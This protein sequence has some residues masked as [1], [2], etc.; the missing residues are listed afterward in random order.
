MAYNYS[1]EIAA[2]LVMLVILLHFFIYRQF[3]MARTGIFGAYVGVSLAGC[4]CNIAS[5]LGCAYPYSLPLWAN[6]VLVVLVFLLE[7]SSCYLFFIY[8]LLICD[9]DDRWQKKL[10][11]IGAIPLFPTIFLILATPFT[12]W[13]YYFDADRQYTRSVLGNVGY[14]LILGYVLA[15]VLLLLSNRRKI[16]RNNR[17]IIMLYSLLMFV[18]FGI[19]LYSKELLLDGIT[20]AVVILLIYVSMQSP[21]SLVDSVSDRYNELAF[22]IVVE[23]K[24]RRRQ[25]FAVLCLHLNKFNNISAVIGYK[26]VDRIIEQ[27]GRFLAQTGG[28]E[29]TYRTESHVFSLILPPDQEKVTE[30]VHKIQERFLQKWKAGNLDL[31]LNANIVTACSPEHFESISEM[32]ALRDYMMEYAKTKG[33]NSLVVADGEVKK[34]YLRL[35]SVERAINKAIE[36]NSLEVFYQPIYSVRE[37]KMVAAEA[38][39]RLHDEVLGNISPGEFIPIAEKNG[40]IIELGKQIFEKCCRFI[41][42]ELVPHPE[43]EISSI[44]VNL[45]VVQCIQPDMSEQFIRIIE[46]YNIPP[47]ML[48]LELTERITLGATE[49]MQ[50]HMRKLDAYG[51]RFALDD[52]GTGSSN[53]AYLID[54]A[55]GMVKFDKQM[56]DSYFENETAHKIL[57]NEF[58]T[59]KELGIDIV[60]EGI[61]TEEQ[62]KRLKEAEMN[63]IQGFYFAKPAPMEQ[64]LELIRTRKQ[65]EKA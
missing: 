12:G 15:E 30:V 38:L 18:G 59:L 52:Y 17:V 63:Y 8:S 58:R 11:K 35:D 2:A 60:V 40:T 42:E 46:K 48:N 22:R 50:A 24:I 26:N 56:M 10:G 6:H 21:G 54:Y 23:E 9:R 27:V 57:S 49:L 31:L 33:T 65:E 51:V 61:E 43:L 34:N 64:F 20:K 28:E 13:M 16:R 3:P 44:H 5:S 14:Y 41:A 32:N 1:F 37:K 55:F 39:A 19:Q 25:R 47:G 36:N 4:L 53:C 7:A 45:S 62:V 29:N